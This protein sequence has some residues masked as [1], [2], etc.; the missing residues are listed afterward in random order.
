MG[1]GETLSTLRAIARTGI[2]RPPRPDRL[3]RM[4]GAARRWGPTPA[5]LSAVSAAR[6]PRLAAV[7][8]AE[9]E[10]DWA[11]LDARTDRIAVGMAER[12]LGAGDTMGIMCR[13][14]RGFVE[15]LVVA[16]KVGADAVLLNTGFAGPQLGQVAHREGVAVLV[17]D[18]AFEPTVRDAGLGDKPRYV[19]WTRGEQA[20]ATTF[21]ELARD[22]TGAPTP[23]ERVSQVVLLSSGTTGTPKGARRSIDAN[24]LKG[25]K[26]QSGG[27]ASQLGLVT[28]LPLRARERT[29]VAAPLFHTWGLSAGLLM[30]A[31]LSNPMVLRE[32]FD[33]EDT[34]GTIHRDRVGAL[35]AVPAMLQRIL[36]LPAEVRQRYDTSSLRVVALSGSTLPGGLATRWMDTFGD[37]LYSLYGS[38]E[39]S[40][41]ALAGPSDLRADPDTAGP[42]LPGI[43]VRLLDESGREVPGAGPGRI[44]V[45]SG[46]LFDGY[47]GGGSKEVIDG[48]MATGDVG[49]V[50]DAGRLSIVGRE[51][52]MI[53]SGGENV[54]PQEVEEVLF[55]HPAVADVA[56]IGVD[57]DQFGQRL[58][59]VV[60]SA[61]LPAGAEELRDWVRSNLAAYKV[62]RDVVFRDELPRNPTG[63][64][65][66]RVLIAEAG[67]Q[68]LPPA[69]T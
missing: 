45:R 65:L 22:S 31:A 61:G 3:V 54:Y 48:F 46:L 20:A 47:S 26:D 19:V 53:V 23:P 16:G 42:I 13:N 21:D 59:A 50:D 8:D 33:A 25:D 27:P 62:P 52:D 12:G 58:H 69:G 17:H 37:N 67:N 4:V 11:T 63:K 1:A 30:S 68:H 41:V 36:D 6:Y 32:R 34:L 10:L 64:V 2:L 60:V 28:R 49:R 55:R 43:Q 40:G 7:I 66:R 39:V 38:T 24:A 29:L 14:H 35:V 15:A 9:G 57:D 56:V 51:D 5:T 44:F 18:H